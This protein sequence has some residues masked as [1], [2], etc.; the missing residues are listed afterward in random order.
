MLQVVGLDHVGINTD[1]LPATIAFYEKLGGKVTKTDR[2]GTLDIVMMDLC[3]AVTLELL[4]PQGACLHKGG[5][6]PIPH[7]ALEVKDLPACIDYVRTQGLEFLTPNYMDL[8]DLL[9]G[10]RV[11]F[12]AGLNGEE[13]ELIEHTGA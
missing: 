5:L 4:A 12:M 2:S 10:I 7:I 9:G 1:N 6:Q 11:I 13:I 3:G 8:P